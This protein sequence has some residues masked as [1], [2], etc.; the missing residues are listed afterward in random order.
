M[1][2]GVCLFLAAIIWVVFGQTLHYQFVNYD[3]DVYVYNNPVVAQGLTLHGVIWAFTNFCASNW[4]PLTMISHMLDC[5]LYGMHPGGHHL[6][7]VLLHTATAILLFLVLRRM[8]GFLWRSALV[9]AVFAIHPLRVESVA[10]VSERKD[11]LSGLFFMLTLWAY[12]RY[13]E[14]AKAQSPRSKAFYRWVLLLFALGLMCKPMLVTLPFVLML[15]DY[16]PLNRV[17]MFA[18]QNP[19]SILR[20]L[21]LEK[22]PLFGLAI[23]SGVITLYAQQQAIQFADHFSLPLRLE[24]AAISYVVY[25]RQ[26]FWPTNLAVLYPLSSERIGLLKV[27]LSLAVLANVSAGAW[28]WRRRCPYLLTGWLWYLIMLVPVMGIVQ[29]GVQAHADRYTY[30]PQIGLYL[31]LAWGAAELGTGWRCRRVVLGGCSII[32]LL[33]LILCARAQTTYWQNSVSLWTHTLACTSDNAEAHNNLGNVLYS[34]QKL[35]KAIA[36]Y[37]KALQIK[38]DYSEAYCNLGNTLALEG[39][40]VQAIAQYQKALQI[41]PDYAEAQNNL[42][43]VLATCPQASLRDGKRA[44]ELARQANQLSG[45]KNPYI[46][47]TLAAAYAE[48]GRF[49]EALETAQHALQ[50]AEARFDPTLAQAIESE[51]ELYQTNTPFHVHYKTNP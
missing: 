48:A 28:F 23:A 7:N 41:K 38:P 25:V 30:L 11:V 33:P 12:V 27:V 3:D 4:H 47:N 24:N 10:W 20:R 13:A 36:Q 1:A 43:W 44:V 40:V 51:M 32:I 17:A 16:W 34:Q 49:P 21:V 42:A 5:E 46:L 9:A 2:F 31:L 8:T 45:G 19:F 39:K 6:T 18:N 26:M 37:Q 50:L 29:V 35:D 15:L 14:E 22:L